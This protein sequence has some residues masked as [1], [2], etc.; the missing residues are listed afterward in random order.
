MAKYGNFSE[1]GR[2][3]QNVMISLLGDEELVKLVHYTDVDKNPLGK[4]VLNDPY[5]L[6]NSKIYPQIFLPPT[7]TEVVYIYVLYQDFKKSAGNPYF[8]NGL[9]DIHIVVHRNLYVIN[10]GLRAYEIAHR[11]DNIM[12]RGSTTNSLSEDWFTRCRFSMV[13]DFYSSLILTYSNWNL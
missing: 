10:D 5:I 11:I 13:N 4:P 8:K 3:I 12:N 2:Q 7:D 6:L 9:I 1:V